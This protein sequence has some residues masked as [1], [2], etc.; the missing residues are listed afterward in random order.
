MGHPSCENSVPPLTFLL[1]FPYKLLQP[2]PDTVI[3]C[4]DCF[5]D[6]DSGDFIL[7]HIP[8]STFR[9][10]EHPLSIFPSTLM[11]R[12]KRR[13]NTA[14][15]SVTSACLPSRF[16]PI[17]PAQQTAPCF[18]M[19]PTRRRQLKKSP[20]RRARHPLNLP[21]HQTSSRKVFNYYLERSNQHEQKHRPF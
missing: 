12:E 15:R 2:D 13:S 11:S 6:S 14:R 17:I 19:R 10:L 9:W 7:T 3:L 4:V 20:L 5:H 8:I 18:T 21:S 16:C 1:P